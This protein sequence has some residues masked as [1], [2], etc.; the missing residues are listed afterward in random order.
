MNE[1]DGIQMNPSSSHIPMAQPVSSDE[2]QLGGQ[3]TSIDE[4]DKV[5]AP[6]KSIDNGAH[7]KIYRKISR[8]KQFASF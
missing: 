2:I 5:E 3:I 1:N 6:E 8:P 4:V 7:R